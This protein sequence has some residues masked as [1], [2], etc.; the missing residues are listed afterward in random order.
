MSKN[1][2]S[3]NKVKTNCKKK[4]NSPSNQDLAKITQPNQPQHTIFQFVHIGDVIQT[5]STTIPPTKA[6]PE[7][8]KEDAPK[9]WVL[10][11]NVFRFFKFVLFTDAGN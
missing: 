1:K 2:R 11:R 5:S 10:I 8:N 3:R 9:S 6:L 7:I 4:Q